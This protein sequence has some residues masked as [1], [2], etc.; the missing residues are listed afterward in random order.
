MLRSV[1]HFL[2]A[3]AGRGMDA[4]VVGRRTVCGDRELHRISERRSPNLSGRVAWWKLF[5]VAVRLVAAFLC[6]RFLHREHALVALPQR[7]LKLV[8]RVPD[9]RPL[10]LLTLRRF[11][12]QR[13]L[14]EHV[15]LHGLVRAFLLDASQHLAR[16]FLLLLLE[17]LP[18]LLL[19]L[20]LNKFL[21]LLSLLLCSSSVPLD[22]LPL[23]LHLLLLYSFQFVFLFLAL[24]LDP[25][26][27]L[28]QL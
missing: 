1:E 23:G 2:D 13:A 24:L 14:L 22:P 27:G 20:H 17:N 8:V 10:L 21:Q 12:L 19:F 28:R 7:V 9:L 26:K 25:H 18:L 3:L 4:A 15:F 16:H 6:A 5:A 11:C